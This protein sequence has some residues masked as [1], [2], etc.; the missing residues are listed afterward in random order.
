MI[1]PGSV[2]SLSIEK[3]AAGGRMIARADGQIVLVSG[4][5]PGERVTAT[6]ER[7]AKGTA[8]ARTMTVDEP[9]PDRREPGGDLLCGGCLLAHVAYPRQL[10]IKSL[11]I[12]DAF[13]RIGR[14][15]LADP[16]RV[17]PSR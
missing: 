13:A 3:P 8:Y 15:P 4:A 12:A 10:Q 14:L 11:V 7:V 6:I 16:V 17:A 9:S 1:S 5:I 2:L